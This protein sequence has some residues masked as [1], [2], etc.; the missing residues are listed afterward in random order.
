MWK[1][2]RITVII[3]AYNEEETIGEVIRALSRF[4]CEILVVDDG[5]YDETAKVAKD[6]GA[7][8][9]SHSKNKGYLEALRTGFKHATG[10]IVVT[11]DADGQHSAEDVPRLLEPILDE[12]ADMVIGARERLS[13]SEKVITMLTRLRVNV[14]DASSGFKALK[15]ELALKMELR[16]KC[17]CGTFVLEAARLGAR[18]EEVKIKVG[19]RKFGKSRVIKRHFAQTFIVIRELLRRSY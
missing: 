5:S 19:E 3:P 4:K 2:K 18:I 7:K 14:S 9:I 16:G 12:R 11:M 15:R 1:Q 8:V 10:D 6:A 13:F 17:V